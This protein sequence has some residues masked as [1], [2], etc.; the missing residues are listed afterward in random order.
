MGVI[1]ATVFFGFC[2]VLFWS[3]RNPFDRKELEIHAAALATLT[4]ALVI[5]VSRIKG[6]H[7]L[8]AAL[9]AVFIFVNYAAWLLWT[10]RLKR[11][12]EV[13]ELYPNTLLNRHLY[14][15][16]PWHVAFLLFTFVM[17]TCVVGLLLKNRSQRSTSLTS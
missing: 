9:A 15:T 2:E 3:V 14:G 11:L 16:R 8:N 17:L 7:L 6:R 4:A 12:A 13:D 5:S 1:F 10:E